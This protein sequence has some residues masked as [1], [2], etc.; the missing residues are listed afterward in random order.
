M[1]GRAWLRSQ[2]YMAAVVANRFNNTMKNYY[3]RKLKE[4]K[5]KKLVLVAIMR[6]MLITLN[7]MCKTGEQYRDQNKQMS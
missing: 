1:G 4:G 6:K 5:S 7:Q 2:L 3:T